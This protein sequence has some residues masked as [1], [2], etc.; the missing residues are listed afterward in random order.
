MRGMRLL[1]AKA[2]ARLTAD[3]KLTIEC[4]LNGCEQGAH[5]VMSR[6]AADESV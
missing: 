6:I 5:T 4:T 1:P 3:G 2:I